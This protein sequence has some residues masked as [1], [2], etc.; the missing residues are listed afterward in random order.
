ML[1]IFLYIIVSVICLRSYANHKQINRIEL[2]SILTVLALIV[3]LGDMLGGYDRYIYGELFDRNAD[4]IRNGG[5]FINLESPIMGYQSEMSYVIW[6]SLVAYITPNRYIFILFTTLF[7]YILLFFSF[8]RMFMEYPISVL[9]FMGL[10]FFFTFTY[11]RQAMAASCTWLGYRYV[12]KR[13]LLKFLIVWFIAY[14]FHNSAVIFLI[15]YFMPQKKWSK[16]TI[17]IVLAVLLVIGATGLPMSLYNLY[18]NAAD[19]SRSMSYADDHS[20]F[21]YD[22]VFEV[23]TMMYLIF[24]RYDKIPEDRENIVYLNAS[25]MFCFILFAF[26]QSSN[27]GRQSWYYIMGIIYLL[28]FLSA[29]GEDFDQYAKTVYIVATILYLRFVFNWGILISP[30]KTFLTN[31]HRQGDI[32]YEIFEYDDHYDEDKFYRK[33]FDIYI[34]R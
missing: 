1:F 11:L 30:Y 6:N 19:S 32:I 9:L 5:P 12:I 18:G 3:G 16:T 27:A 25:L 2:I 21:R 33:P 29:K 7:I 8:R 15:F 20:G 26:I 23:V 22:Y 14:K 13:D 28:S 17:V 4:L 31:G 24:N 10:W 34:P